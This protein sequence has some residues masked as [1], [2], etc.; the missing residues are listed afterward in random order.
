MLGRGGLAED[1][2]QLADGLLALGRQLVGAGGEG[3]VAGEAEQAAGRVVAEHV[4]EALGQLG[5]R[6]VGGGVERPDPDAGQAGVQVAQGTVAGFELGL[7]LGDEALGLVLGQLA[8][9]GPGAQLLDGALGAGLLLAQG[10]VLSRQRA[11]GVALL[12]VL[13]LVDAA[14]QAGPG[15]QQGRQR[16]GADA[17]DT[18]QRVHALLRQELG[19]ADGAGLGPARRATIRP[20]DLSACVTDRSGAHQAV[21]KDPTASIAADIR[22][23]LGDGPLGPDGRATLLISAAGVADD[24]GVLAAP[25]AVLVGLGRVRPEPVAPEV[26]AVRAGSVRVLAV[27][28]PSDVAGHPGARGAARA[29][30]PGAVLVPGLVNAHTHLDLTHIGP[31][32]AQGGFIGFARAVIAG[33]HRA[34]AAIEAS[35]RRGAVASLRGGVVAV[36]DIA[37]AAVDGGD[38]S[39]GWRAVRAALA[40]LLSGVCAAEVIDLRGA[41]VPA[42]V[43]QGGP[44]WDAAAEPTSG[45]PRLRCG[46]SPHAPYTVPL[47]TYRAMRPL[48][49]AGA[50]IVT[51]LA[52]TPEER[53]LLTRGDGPLAG[54]FEAAGLWDSA[55]AARFPAAGVAGAGGAGGGGGQGAWSGG[56]PRSPVAHLARAL[57]AWSPKERSRVT[58]VHLNDLDDQDAD[59]VA[60]S[61]CAVV[62]CPR[63]SAYFDAPQHFG[64]HRYRQLRARGVP[65]AL[66]TDSVMN[67]PP[68]R[69]GVE[70]ISVL[71]EARALVQRDGLGPDIALGLIT[72]QGARVLGQPEEGFRIQSGGWLAGLVAVGVPGIRSG[73]ARST[74]LDAVFGEDGPVELLLVADLAS[75]GG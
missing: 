72:T 22:Q 6:A 28:S 61:G 16:Q 10:L 38:P 75:A 20:A 73:T 18:V 54:F 68:S 26:P 12:V 53:R 34:A 58:L 52:E 13:R 64:A 23:A 57:D 35:A 36:G 11:D 7:E 46:V 44:W 47:E 24:R 51:H 31:R 69:D 1:P 25:G 39:A 33:R 56:G 48:A 14:A 37:G 21:N 63:S 49:A 3:D 55:M 29:D 74:V 40:G 45:R 4:G 70:T 32:P 66:G 60:Q 43:V 42:G 5:Q 50:P 30:A 15:H 17:G 19:G 2:R 9:V 8:A 65:V 62:Y 71:D 41:G 59:W 27:G 67:L